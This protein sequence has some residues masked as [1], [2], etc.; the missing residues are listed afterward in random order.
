MTEAT[1]VCCSPQP[2][3]PTATARSLLLRV[4]P[5]LTDLAFLLPIFILFAIFEGPRKLLSDGD[6]GWHIRT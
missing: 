2:V 5:S 1:I 4:L 6:T 3:T